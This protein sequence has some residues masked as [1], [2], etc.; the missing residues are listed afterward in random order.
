MAGDANEIFYNR[1]KYA[2]FSGFP[3]DAAGREGARYLLMA[4]NVAK[5]HFESSHIGFSSN[6]DKVFYMR[7]FQAKLFLTRI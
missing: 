3:D 4:L 2:L 5:T 1:S 7:E 6:V